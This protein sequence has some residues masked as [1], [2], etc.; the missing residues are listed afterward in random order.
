MQ[1]QE[2][3]A[4][5]QVK[6]KWGM[7]C[8]AVG[9]SLA[10][11]GCANLGKTEDKDQTKEVKEETKEDNNSQKKTDN[12]EDSHYSPI[13]AKDV[14][15]PKVEY[16]YQIRVNRAMNCVTV[17]TMNDKEEY[18]VPVC[19]ML[20]STGGENVPIG[21]FQLGDSARWHML[22]DGKYTQ[23]MNRIVDNVVFRSVEYLAQS[24]DALDVDSF[25]R[26]G[27]TVSDSAVVLEAASAL[28]IYENCPEGTQVEIYDD[29][30]EAGPLGRPD[31]RLIS[32]EI[33]WD[34]T[35]ASSENAWYVPV[36]FFG[37]SDRTIAPGEKLDL[38]NGVTAKDKRGNDLTAA[39][40]VY[41][42]VDVNKE[43]KYTVTYSCENEDGDRREVKSS[44]TVA[45]QEKDAETAQA[46]ANPTQ[47]PADP[48]QQ[49][50]APATERPN[51]TAAQNQTITASQNQAQQ[52]TPAQP[53]N[54][55]A[56]APTPT[57][58]PAPMMDTTITTVEII[59]QT[60]PQ[61]ALRATSCYVNSLSE[62]VLRNRINVSDSQSGV[63]TVDIT[64]YPVPEEGNYI[65]FY[66]AFDK[67][68]N[69]ACIAETVYLR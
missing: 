54:A 19:A 16:P 57:Q 47:T 66:E 6:R 31:N 53:T 33:T 10:L 49:P 62:A 20:C 60:P 26:L 50:T 63:L 11:S 35:D 41:G 67:V 68:G 3:G 59:D 52:I 46:V 13:M 14:E 30:K 9:M 65:V 48:T 12:Q 25:N 28:W 43:G 18:K 7:L 5:L 29:E 39:I 21:T 55:P 24:E 44:V 40:R 51:E 34:P 1:R 45:G 56:V 42:E 64:V 4:D 36:S 58:Q 17:Y 22:S 27:E 8:L 69:S 32:D 37:I 61:I 2:K 15:I 23:Y 38:L